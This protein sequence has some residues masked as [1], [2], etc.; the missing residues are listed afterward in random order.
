MGKWRAFMSKVWADMDKL[1]AFTNSRQNYGQT[2]GSH[3]KIIRRQKWR[4]SI[5][6]RNEEAQWGNNRINYFNDEALTWL[7][8]HLMAHF[9]K[10]DIYRGVVNSWLTQHYR[11]SF[12]T[13][14]KIQSDT[15]WKNQG[16]AGRMVAVSLER[17]MTGLQRHRSNA[18]LKQRLR[19]QRQCSPSNSSECKLIHDFKICP[20][21]HILCV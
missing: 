13:A 19:H 7:S 8:N 14:G 6:Y 2:M 11:R 9:N 4:F 1:R 15:L 17:T 5:W 3:V 16:R 21:V 12:L 10:Y 20:V 18:S